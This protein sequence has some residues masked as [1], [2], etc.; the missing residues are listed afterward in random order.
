MTAAP[1]DHAG[2]QTDAPPAARWRA[3]VAAVLARAGQP[4]DDP[5]QALTT[6]TLDGLAIKPL[7]TEVD[8]PYPPS[9]L[10]RPGRAPFV[11]GTSAPSAGWDVR[12]RHPAD[13]PDTVNAAVRT[14]LA[15]GVT[16]IWLAGEIDDL[17][18]VLAG[19]ELAGT[20]I[21]LD[22]EANALGAAAAL[23]EVAGGVEL[24]GNLGAD[25]IGWG[26]R[27]GVAPELQ[28]AVDAVALTSGSPLLQGICVDGTVYHDAGA[29]DVAELAIVTSAGVAYLRAL[30]D[31]GVGIAEALA[32]LEFRLAVTDDQFA[33]MAKLRAARRLWNRVG[34]LCDAPEA[35][36]GQRQH[37]VT[38]G[39]MMTRR[40]PFTNLLRTT[41]AG[42]AAAV[43]GAQ[44]I[45]VAPFDQALGRSD[46]LARR[47]ARNTQAV[48][49]DEVSL[50][51]V[52]DPA[53]GS[54]YVESLTDHM[55]EAAWDAFTELER[56]G[57]ATDL[58]AVSRLIATNRSRRDQAIAAGRFPITGVNR[59]A[60]DEEEPLIRKGLAVLTG[61][62]LPRIRWAE[63][64]EAGWPADEPG[65]E[66]GTT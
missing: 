11:R 10:G 13:D 1:T 56:S 66:G 35:A 16:S 3:M 25:P 45:T 18:T 29:G 38:S 2:A 8:L 21:V 24:S 50:A 46:D 20:P 28:M 64:D 36:R 44:A 43:A 26:H 12:Q 32:A 30:T 40:D 6:T 62:G 22:A 65:R 60:N 57:G 33:S 14:D 61:G 31:A 54:W 17:A 48:L 34:E 7:Y 5:E 63:A 58:D 19:V 55:A 9:A 49:H 27:S 59:F 42:F 52:A 47:I 53:G 41:L 23:F 51:R 37:A 39:A 4:A 15:S